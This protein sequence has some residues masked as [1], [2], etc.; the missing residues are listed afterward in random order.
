MAPKMISEIEKRATKELMF[1]KGLELIKKNG[2]SNMSVSKITG[3][4]GLGKSTF[5]NYFD[6]KEIFVLE[7]IEYGHVKFWKEVEK[8]KNDNGIISVENMKRILNSIVFN[9]DSIY[10][11]LSTEEE[12]KI[13]DA[14]PENKYPD[15]NE[16]TKILKRLF[17][18][19][20]NIKESP[21][22]AVISNLLKIIA[23]S[24]QNKIYLHSSGFEKT[25]DRLYNLLYKEIFK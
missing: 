14:V 18:Y 9:E 2:F 3:G 25:I 11:Y 8:L 16:E 10:Q 20:E 5:Y 6:S 12:I 15:I 17:S 13:K 22:Y 4:V 19:G 1:N 24:T 23:L 7:M 21:D